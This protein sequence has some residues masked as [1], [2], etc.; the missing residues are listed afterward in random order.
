MR[1]ATIIIL[2]VTMSSSPVLAHV[3]AGAT[4]VVFSGALPCTVV[5]SYWIDN[6]FTPCEA[7]FPRG[8]YIDHITAPAPT[9]PPTKVV[10]LEATLDMEIDWDMFL[11]SNT[12]P[13]REIE[14]GIGT[15]VQPPCD[16]RLG[17]NNVIPIGCHEDHS[18]PV[19]AG[20]T[21]ILRAYNWSDP[22]DATGRYSFTVI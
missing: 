3:R 14:T 16:N 13:P 19:V 8:S 17:P 6:G 20:Q 22:L 9:P 2:L 1:R 5:C 4:E 10:A 15:P 12:T 7:P 18:T 21:V 11:C